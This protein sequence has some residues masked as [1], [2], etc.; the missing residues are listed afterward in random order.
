MHLATRRVA[1]LASLALFTARIALGASFSGV[2][3][4]ILMHSPSF[5][6]AAT[7][8]GM[9]QVT[10]DSA[11]SRKVFNAIH[12][13]APLLARAREICGATET[14]DPE[15]ACPFKMEVDQFMAA[16]SW[17]A[18]AWDARTGAAPPTV[19]TESQAAQ[20]PVV[21]VD[22][23]REAGDVIRVLSDPAVDLPPDLEARAAALKKA[24]EGAQSSI[25]CSPHRFGLAVA[26][27]HI[28]PDTRDGESIDGGS[29]DVLS[30]TLAARPVSTRRDLLAV[31]V[32]HVAIHPGDPALAAESAG[33]G[34]VGIQYSL[35]LSRPNDLGPRPCEVDPQVEPE[36]CEWKAVDMDFAVTLPTSN[37]DNMRGYGDY[38]VYAGGRWTRESGHTRQK[39]VGECRSEHRVVAT[40]G[41]FENA[42]V[43]HMW[44]VM[45]SIAYTHAWKRFASSV[46]LS[47]RFEPA[48]EVIFDDGSS[49]P[50]AN[51]YD[52]DVGFELGPL[53]KLKTGRTTECFIDLLARAALDDDA[54]RDRLTPTLALQCQWGN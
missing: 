49:R 31:T 27:S 9:P 25:E 3:C 54:V 44:A 40:G 22:V 6:S 4:E 20:R 41:L 35:P 28:T 33:L 15:M 11:V 10:R 14:A 1:L 19:R 36:Q 37:G 30:A 29:V 5:S 34:D 12:R 39:V 46:G 42:D 45:A 50:G 47:G 16:A 43:E 53:G 24:L 26:F 51:R 38:T 52:L 13:N 17:K 32:R 48:D 21:A 8:L 18:V 2:R 23:A 7:N